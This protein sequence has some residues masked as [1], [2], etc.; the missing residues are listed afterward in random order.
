MA[1]FYRSTC[2]MF[3]WPLDSAWMSE[4][5]ATNTAELAKL[6][7]TLASAE[8]EE[9]ESE[10][11]AALR[12][13]AEFYMRIGE[14]TLALEAFDKTCMPHSSKCTTLGHVDESHIRALRRYNRPPLGLV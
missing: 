7:E 8:Q 5:E 11:C 1:P 6:A 9:G 14:K 3:S 2:E 4:M 10:I 12:A 13:R